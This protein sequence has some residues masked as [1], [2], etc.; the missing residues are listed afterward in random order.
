MSA[1]E[2]LFGAPAG[3]FLGMTLL[4]FGGAAL[5]TGRALGENWR[6]A[7]QAVLYALLLALGDRFLLFALFAGELLSPSGFAIA[8]IFLALVCLAARRATLAR[9]MVRQYPWLYV[10]AG[11][12]SWRERAPVESLTS[13]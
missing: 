1:I 12:F 4:L 10:S 11:P 5:M 8:A 2:A 6:A 3:A 9:R 7:W 13:R